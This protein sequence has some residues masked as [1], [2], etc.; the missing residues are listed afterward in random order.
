M[1]CPNCGEAAPEDAKWCEACGQDLNSEP[2]PACVSCG[3]REVAEEGYCLSCGHKQPEERDHMEFDAG[4]AVGVTDRGKRHRHNEDAVAIGVTSDGTAVLV[5]CD[6]VSSTPGSAEASLRASTAARDLLLAGLEPAPVGAE[7]AEDAVA[8]QDAVKGENA[9]EIDVSALLTRAVE[10]AQVEAT[11]T[12]IDGD[13]PEQSNAPHTDGGPP[14][15]TFVA[16]V[17]RPTIAEPDST[18]SAGG[19][20]GTDSTGST[21]LATAWV[22]D[23]RAYW[24]GDESSRLTPVD[25]ELEGSLV[26]WLGADSIDPTPDI[27]LNTVSGPGHV[28]VCS[29]GLWRYA[30]DVGELAELV[31]RLVTDGKH[32][33]GLASAMVDFANEGGG[34]DNISVALWSNVSNTAEDDPLTDA[35]DNGTDSDS[36]TSDAPAAESEND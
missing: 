8:A 16:V 28:V 18:D 31:G 25:H 30:S 26:R 5:V 4:A 1:D 10:A 32:G 35:A 34:H 19:T 20:D 2:L 27:A 33:L 22:G 36:T 9:A 21:E 14:S 6:G 13:G 11:A 17:A 23:S 29:D 7:S 3:E 12:V 24:V 15:S